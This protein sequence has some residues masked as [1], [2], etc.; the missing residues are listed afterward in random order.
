MKRTSWMS[1]AAAAVLCLSAAA[2]AA[3]DSK[4]LDSGSG[5][6]GEMMEPIRNADPEAHEFLMQKLA[7]NPD[8]VKKRMRG[9]PPPALLK[10]Y[11]EARASF[12]RVIKAEMRAHRLAASFRG[13]D[14]KNRA[15]IRQ[16]LRTA[17]GELFDARVAGNETRIQIMQKE[18]VRLKEQLEKRRGMRDKLVDKR[19]AELTS[20]EEGWDW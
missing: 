20:D 4:E 18:T 7:H 14:A 16:E 6:V 9:L 12:I 17:L 5:E 3:K 19:L 11:P 15:G 2:W 1:G 10:R 13:A 8:A